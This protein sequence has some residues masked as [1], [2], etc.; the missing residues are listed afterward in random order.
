[1]PRSPWLI[2]LIHPLNL[3]MIML[4]IVAGLLSAWWLFPLGMLLWVV[5][6]VGVARDPSLRL[7][8]RI[9][10]RAPL[11][12]RFQRHFDRIT[13]AQ[14]NIF[15]I[16]ATTPSATRRVLAPVQTEVD[17]L[18]EQVYSLCWRM[19]A[20]EN[21]RLVTQAQ[22]HL[23]TDLEHVNRALAQTTDPVLRREYEES[24]Q[25][26]V[27]RLSKLEAV[28]R[29]LDRVEA[30]LLSLISEME[31]MIAEVARLQA[32]KPQEAQPR[33]GP[34]VNALRQQARELEGFEKEVITVDEAPG[35]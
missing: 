2:A 13:R 28:A 32:L 27:T 3:V 9:L 17:A 21:Y 23:Q 30:Q 29:Q 1:M 10:S 34:L 7:N 11:A 20:L 6:V 4:A 26:L 19:T 22:S 31:S 35:R 24:R 14:V 15:N 5:M 25:A 8:Q 33:V 16:L 18:V 12:Q